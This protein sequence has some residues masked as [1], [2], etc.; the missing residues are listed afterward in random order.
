M[1][2]NTVSLEK[3]KKKKATKFIGLLW[4][5]RKGERRNAT[6]QPARLVP[7]TDIGVPYQ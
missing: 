6:T 1:E 3:K 2:E 5:C 4:N 7:V